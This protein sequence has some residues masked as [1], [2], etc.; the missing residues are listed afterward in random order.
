[1]VGMP[2]FADQRDVLVRLQQ[3]GVARGVDKMDDS[4]HIYTAIVDVL[5]NIS[6]RENA[7]KL[8]RILRHH[9]QKPLDHALWLV[10]HVAD[11]QGAPHLKFSARHLNFFQFFGLDVL[12]FVVVVVLLLRRL[13]RVVWSSAGRVLG[14]LVPRAKMKQS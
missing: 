8:S 9:P 6:Y 2:V 1:M 13:L 5:T 12:V 11:T 3:R 10:E 14:A 4:Q 7:Q